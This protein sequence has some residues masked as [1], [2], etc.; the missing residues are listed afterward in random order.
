MLTNPDGEP[1]LDEN[2]EQITNTEY[3]YHYDI[4][5]VFQDKTELNGFVKISIDHLTIV[6]QR[7]DLNIDLVEQFKTALADAHPRAPE[8]YEIKADPDNSDHFL[9]RHRDGSK[10]KFRRRK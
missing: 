8:I 10:N 9:V 2:G 3:A 6:L 7:T 4:S 1:L 5:H